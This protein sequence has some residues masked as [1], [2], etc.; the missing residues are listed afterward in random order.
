M[1]VHGVWDAPGSLGH[2]G[3][4]HHS[5][6]PACGWPPSSHLVL[7]WGLGGDMAGSAVSSVFFRTLGPLRPSGAWKGP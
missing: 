1:R 7:G 5:E 4:S 6:Q 3:Q 2:R